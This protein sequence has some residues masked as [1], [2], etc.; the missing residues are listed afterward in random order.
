MKRLGQLGRLSRYSVLGGMVVLIAKAGDF[1]SSSYE[2]AV[3][4]AESLK[5]SVVSANFF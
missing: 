2:P 1:Y 5:V 3:V 4:V